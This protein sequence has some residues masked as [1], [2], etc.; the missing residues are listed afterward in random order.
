M[1]T[2]KRL[3][4]YQPNKAFAKLTTNSI[5]NSITT[6]A[7]G[8]WLAIFSAVFPSL[9]LNHK[10]HQ[11]CPVCGGKD[12]FRLF[13]D[14]EE[15]GGAICNQCGAGNGITWIMRFSNEGFAEACKLVE[16]IL[17]I[18]IN[19]SSRL[20]LAQLTAI[21]KLRFKQYSVERKNEAETNHLEVAK[22]ACEIWRHS[23]PVEENE[24]LTRKRVLPYGVRQLSGV[25][26]IPLI[27]N[28][29]AL[30]N[31]QRIHRDGSK[32][33]LKDGRINGL[34][35]LIGACSLPVSGPLYITEGWSTGATVH[36]LSGQ[37]V[38]AAMN[39]GNLENVARAIRVKS[40]GIQIV[41]AADDDRHNTLNVGKLKAEKAAKALGLNLITP[42]FCSSTCGCT[43]FNDWA[44][45][46]DRG[47]I[48]WN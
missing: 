2:K 1:K 45:C 4:Q 6:I 41:I 5:T 39:A 18:D 32:R 23:L 30:W 11:P 20:D 22:K 34:F 27:D 16:R 25:L 48:Q 42:E 9:R 35:S 19:N 38:A 8:K 37:P 12:R 21:S 46:V 47:V 26:L 7:A 44:N 15:T 33:F 17:G 43:D 31:L 36:K 28:N 40:P 24:Y 3:D 10:K 29:G 14:W 13:P